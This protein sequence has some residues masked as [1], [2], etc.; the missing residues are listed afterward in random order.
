MHPLMPFITEEIWQKI[1]PMIDRGGKTIMC[2][3]F[4]E[5]DKKYQD[6]VADDEIDWLKQVVVNVR[7]IRSEMGVSPAKRIDL[8]L[9]KGEKQDRQRINDCEAFLKSLARVDNIT[10]HTSKESLPASASTVVGKLDIHIPLAGLI[11][12]DAE[13]A[14][15]KK[16]IGKLRKEQEKS[17]NKLSNPSYVKKAPA[18][19]VQLERDRLSVFEQTLKKLEKHFER[20]ES[21]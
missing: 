14:R 13:I 19:V 3:A 21:L 18:E 16:E 5:F 9:D 1:S 8:I 7:T 12:K 10:W 20:I 6:A 2:E 15:L 4:P 17:T 11:D